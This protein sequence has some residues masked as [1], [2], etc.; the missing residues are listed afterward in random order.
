[1]PHREMGADDVNLVF[2]AELQSLAVLLDGPETGP[3]K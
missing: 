3:Q 2:D 1:M